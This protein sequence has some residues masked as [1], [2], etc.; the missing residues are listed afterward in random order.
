MSRLA[1]FGGTPERR[2]PFPSWPAFDENEEEALLE[3]LRSGNWWRYSHGEAVEGRVSEGDQP[4]SKVAEFQE[5]FARFQGARY[6]IACANGSAALEVALKALGVGPGD[7][8]IVPPYTFT[9]S[10][11]V[12]VAINV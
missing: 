3:V 11:A 7:E 6:G 10:A 9:A 8:V 5:A 4:R 2:K 12:A 1:I